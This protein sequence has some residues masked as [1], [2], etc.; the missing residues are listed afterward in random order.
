MSLAQTA[1]TEF[2]KR[3]SRLGADIVSN[4]IAYALA[5]H[6]D[7]A[8]GRGLQMAGD[9]SNLFLGLA[10]PGPTGPNLREGETAVGIPGA[11]ADATFN[12]LTGEVVPTAVRP[13]AGGYSGKKG[14]AVKTYAAPEGSSKPYLS[15]VKRVAENPNSFMGSIAQTMYDNPETVSN[16]VRYGTP[17]VGLGA[18]AVGLHFASKPR[19]VYSAAVTGNPHLG[20][21]G[22]PSI[23]SAR[24]ASY[25]RSQEQDKKFQ[26]AVY[27]RQLQAEA[28]TPGNQ[29]I[30][31]VPTYGGGNPIS[32]LGLG[33]LENQAARIYG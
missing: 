22:N 1:G 5:S 25:F 2:V 33:M 13:E 32:G 9:V 24:A 28:R 7:K 26:H 29:G 21:T 16:L 23:D 30:G 19:S 6:G 18:A 17:A 10:S 11:L 4:A 15:A 31:G 27:L 20:E 3:G 8:I 12:A 14:D